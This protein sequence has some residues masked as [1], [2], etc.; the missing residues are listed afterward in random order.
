[1][2]KIRKLTP[3]GQAVKGV[4]AAFLAPKLAQDSALKPGELDSLLKG[5]KLAG[6][7]EQKKEIFDAVKSTFGKRLAQDASV[8]DLAD[9]LDQLESEDYD[10][11]DMGEDKG[12]IAGAAD[13]PGD[14]GEELMKCLAECNLPP[15]MLEKINGLVSKL[16]KPAGAIDEDL[17]AADKAKATAKDKF[18]EKGKEDAMPKPED[19]KPAMDAAA[20]ERSVSARI[21]ARFQAAEDVQPYIG[22]V[23]AMAADSAEAIYKLALDAAK[24]DLTG[25][26]V[27][28][29]K[30][31]VKML[32]KPDES[33]PTGTGLAADAKERA[34][35]VEQYPH[36]PA[37]V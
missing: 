35:F 31:L 21:A 10:D 30:S 2:G 23:N 29:Y 33:R 24:V 16:A 20:M 34:S 7:A 8:E 15:E 18:P 3:Q 13:G 36:I 1:M 32:P 12:K 28:A 4:L 22:K 17:E 37:K 9:L 19:K 5:I 11:D 25:V 26:P 6:Y 14:P 27:G